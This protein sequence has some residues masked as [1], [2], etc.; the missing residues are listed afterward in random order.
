MATQ[1]SPRDRGGKP[2]RLSARQFTAMIDQGIIPA[3]ARVELLWGRLIEHP[4]RSPAHDFAVGALGE[5]LRKLERTPWLVRESKSL[6]L[7]PTSRV[8]PDLS[9]VRGPSDLFRSRAPGVPDLGL[10]IEVADGTYPYDRGVK[11]RAYASKMVPTYW[12]V[13]L[14]TRQVE[15]Y[16]DP[17]GRGKTASYREAS[18]FDQGTTIQVVVEGHEIGRVAVK[19]VIPWTGAS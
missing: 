12:I 10:L 15:V 19:D 17:Q 1:A 13:N 11:W 3:E 7:G 5:Q 4:K 16:R 18:F 6:D 14:N 2:C 9:L 8:G